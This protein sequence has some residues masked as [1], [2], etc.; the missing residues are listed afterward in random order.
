MIE[1]IVKIIEPNREYMYTATQSTLEL[2]KAELQNV[3]DGAPKGTIH[4]YVNTR[5][6]KVDL[7]L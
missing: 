3:L 2:C 1:Y 7:S 5:I 4:L 6:R